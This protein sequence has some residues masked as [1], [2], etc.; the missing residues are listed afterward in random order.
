M[1]FD[2]F[3]TV[4]V[5]LLPNIG[6][7][8]GRLLL[9]K[10]G[11]FRGIATASFRELISIDSIDV[12]IAKSIASATKDKEFIFDIEKTIES[13]KR[14]MEQR[15][16]QLVTFFDP[17][18][19]QQ[20]KRVYD[21]PIFLFRS[22][23]YSP[24]DERAVAIVGTRTPSEYGRDAAASLAR[25]LAGHGITIVS[26]L[27]MGI[28]TVAHQSALQSNGRTI[29]VLGS[30]IANIYPSA[31][32]NLAGSIPG[33]GCLFSEFALR[34]KPDAQNFPRR[35][36]I[37]SGLSMAVVVVESRLTGG[38]II[39]AE[40]AF[41]QNREVFA[42]PGSIFSPRSEGCHLLFKRGMARPITSAQ[43]IFDELPVLAAS[44]T[45]KPGL[46]IQ[47]T[48]T[49]QAI[50][51]ALTPEPI[52]IDGLAAATSLSTSELL[53]H[54]LRLEFSGLIRQLPGK[55][56]IPCR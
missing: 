34:A 46:S 21:S 35:N 39:T 13:N 17:E 28:D 18:Y 31:N 5:S 32:A 42:V 11:D 16:I 2:P 37:I 33:N 56:F 40:F 41:D 50:L 55:H 47:L 54:L 30:G 25:S 26:G 52:H 15:N 6:A 51:D 36:R 27:A 48:L 4:R 45:K 3:D 20:L 1:F 44:D 38:S 49:E 7:H 29:A 10:F 8:R 23:D 24:A 22:G 19:P 9:Q 14:L 53:V 12:T 43:D